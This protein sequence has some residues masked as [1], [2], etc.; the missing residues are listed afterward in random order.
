[1]AP[2]IGHNQPAVVNITS[3]TPEQTERVKKAILELDG[4]LTRQ[5][6]ERDLQKQ[7]IEDLHETMGLDKKTMRRVAKTYFKDNMNEETE[8]YDSFETSY[9]YLFPTK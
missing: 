9:R 6:A 1:M 8:N 5:A 4:S 3:L 2:K 7:I